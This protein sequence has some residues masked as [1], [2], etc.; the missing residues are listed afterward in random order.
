MS[1]PF[2]LVNSHFSDHKTGRCSSEPMGD[3]ETFTA[4]SDAAGIGPQP[5][6]GHTFSPGPEHKNHGI[7]FPGKIIKWKFQFIKGKIKS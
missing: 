5:R 6:L 2:L 7:F 1:P 3:S 4:P